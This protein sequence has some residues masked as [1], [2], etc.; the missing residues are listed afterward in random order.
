MVANYFDYFLGLYEWK[1]SIPIIKGYD[2]KN[3][4]K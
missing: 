3:S 2:K 1:V 4:K